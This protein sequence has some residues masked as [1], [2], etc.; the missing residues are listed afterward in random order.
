MERLMLIFYDQILDEMALGDII[1]LCIFGLLILS[2]VLSALS[3]IIFKKKVGLKSYYLD[4]I[5]IKSKKDYADSGAK[6]Y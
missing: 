2:I 5:A 4:Q 1:F 3:T 6:R